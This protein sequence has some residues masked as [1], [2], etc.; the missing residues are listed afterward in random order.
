M[1]CK[2]LAE[3]AIP[4]VTTGDP[5]DMKTMGSKIFRK[6]LSPFSFSID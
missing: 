1:F 2:V 5:D 6:K 3:R 4:D